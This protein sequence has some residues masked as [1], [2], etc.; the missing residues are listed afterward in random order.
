MSAFF[1]SGSFQ[2]AGNATVVVG[3]AAAPTRLYSF[4]IISGGTAGSVNLHNSSNLVTPWMTFSGTIST[5]RT[6]SFGEKG[7]LFP[8]GLTTINDTNVTTAIFNISQ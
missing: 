4:H 2:T 5:G 7:I 8:D 3:K 1:N 6:F